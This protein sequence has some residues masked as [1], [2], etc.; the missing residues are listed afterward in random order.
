MTGAGNISDDELLVNLCRA[1]KGGFF[2]PF[3]L[4]LSYIFI[5]C[6]PAELFTAAERLLGHVCIHYLCCTCCSSRSLHVHSRWPH[7]TRE[8]INS[9]APGE[10]NMYLK[11]TVSKKRLSPLKSKTD[12][13]G[14]AERNLR[15]GRL[16]FGD[17]FYFHW[18]IAKGME[19]EGGGT[20]LGKK[21]RSTASWGKWWFFF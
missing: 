6:W 1:Q 16:K 21:P 9:W 2:S 8:R 19:V 11:N 12:A 18:W 13:T 5:L 17:A 20:L 7:Q 4:S 14:P 3:L 15:V 10:C